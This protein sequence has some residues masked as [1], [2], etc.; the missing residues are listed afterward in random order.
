MIFSTGSRYRIRRKLRADAEAG[1]AAPVTVWEIVLLGAAL[2]LA[3]LI[4]APPLERVLSSLF[5]HAGKKRNP[6][7]DS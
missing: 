7:G 2:R 5:L 4:F 3:I 1:G 6:P